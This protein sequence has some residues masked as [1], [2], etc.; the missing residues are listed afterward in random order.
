MRQLLK[1]F[2]EVE[3]W[4]ESFEAAARK[5]EET[6]A[7]SLFPEIPE[8][9]CGVSV[10]PLTI[11]DW[12]VMDV[13][14]NPYTAGGFI[15][16]EHALKLLWLLRRRLLWVGHGRF[17][18]YVQ[19]WQSFVVLARHDFDEERVID[20]VTEY[21]DAAF[22][23]MPGINDVKPQGAGGFNATKLPHVAT[24]V[25][26]CSEIMAAYPSFR[27]AD[28]TAMPLAQFWQW[29]NQARRKA[30]PEYKNSQETDLVNRAALAEKNRINKAIRA[31]QKAQKESA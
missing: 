14:R 29:L 2:M 19:R 23:D 16:G 8:T 13:A 27:Y 9:L 12:T 24:E 7:S 4:R 31:E 28:L 15:A 21:V 18:R 3:G 22:M 26:L 5:Q 30:D 10:R 6:R 17:A 25:S 11:R 1:S 20:S